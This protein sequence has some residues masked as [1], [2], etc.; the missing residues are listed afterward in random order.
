MAEQ[1]AEILRASVKN[2]L[3]EKNEIAIMFSGGVDSAILA[4]IARKFC[5]VK[6]FVAGM[7]GS[8]DL[9]WGT[10]AGELLDLPVKQIIFTKEDVLQAMKNVVLTHNMHN[11]RWMSTFTA[12]DIVLSRIDKP[13]A[14]CGQGADELFGGYKKYR[15]MSPKDAEIR[16]FADYEE[17]AFQEMP[18]YS[19]MAGHYGV[20]LI[21][22]YLNKDIVDFAGRTPFE[23][24][25]G[26]VTFG[27][28]K[29]G[30][31]NKE[32]LRQAAEILGVPGSMARRPKKAM[33]Y[34]SGISKVIKSYIKNSENDL[35]GIIDSIN[36]IG[37]LYE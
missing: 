21:A 30:Q 16:M 12:F 24:K 32:I 6:L 2:S 35:S 29:H 25:L 10:E 11:P 23:Q 37:N 19:A 8:N 3:A 33:Q 36:H 14:F 1:L 26:E 27:R 4:V 22:P 17:L 31:N 18:V 28:E 9:L 20:V 5:D 15:E 34:G 13:V 7:E